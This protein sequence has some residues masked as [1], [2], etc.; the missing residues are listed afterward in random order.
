M[1]VIKLAKFVIFLVQIM[2]EEEIAK[3]AEQQA[4]RAVQRERRL[5][6][7]HNGAPP[8]EVPVLAT[9]SGSKA[10]SAAEGKPSKKSSRNGPSSSAYGS[11]EPAAFAAA[12][13][14]RLSRELSLKEAESNMLRR[15]NERLKAE[16]LDLRR[17][18]E[19]AETKEKAD[20]L[21][22]NEELKKVNCWKTLFCVC[23]A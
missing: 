22:E 5:E 14:S 9:G 10:A 2:S 11:G 8:G 16:A 21:A 20:V 19:Q 13:A 12:A 1:L 4:E 23:Y 15:E 3:L 18:L 6:E 7:L 17:R